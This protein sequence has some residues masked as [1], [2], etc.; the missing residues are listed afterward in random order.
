MRSDIP[1]LTLITGPVVD[2]PAVKYPM[3]AHAKE[4]KEAEARSLAK[5]EETIKER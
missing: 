5:V 1:P 4:N 3:D 2:W